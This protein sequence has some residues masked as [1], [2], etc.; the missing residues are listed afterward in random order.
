MVASAAVVQQANFSPILSDLS[1]NHSKGPVGKW[2]HIRLFYDGI[3]L[4]KCQ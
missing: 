2:G 4:N 1:F 3:V